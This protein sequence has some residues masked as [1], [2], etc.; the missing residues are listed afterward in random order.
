MFRAGVKK[1]AAE[2][3]PTRTA[4]IQPDPTRWIDEHGDYL[5]AYAFSRL[6][7]EAAAED[8]VQETLLAGIQSLKTFSG[9]S[10]ERTWLT[11]ILKHKI[12]DHFRRISKVDLFDPTV[13]NLSEFDPLFARDDEWT[14][15]WNPQLSPSDW[16]MTPESL[17]EESE[18]FETFRSCFD[19]L[20]R[21]V[22]DV[23]ALREMEGLSGEQV[24]EVLS[25][26]SNNFWVIMH[27]A[28]M[29]LRRCLEINWFK[30]V[31]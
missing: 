4:P 9:K 5:Y 21:K 28:R 30:G 20:P 3:E 8:A 24:C 14:N 27:R 26:S 16:K 19:K 15:H 11:G 31:Q 1:Q 22:A 17:L 2:A 13:L 29:S 25:L 12:L 10:A 6:R 23:F 7:D 18:F